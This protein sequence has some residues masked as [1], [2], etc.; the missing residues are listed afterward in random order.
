MSWNVGSVPDI[1]REPAPVVN[2]STIEI[3]LGWSTCRVSKTER[4]TVE[5]LPSYSPD[6]NPIEHLWR[7]IKRHNTHNRSFPA[8]SDLMTAV[9]TAL[10]H[11]QQHASE[12]KQLMGTYLDE[13]I[14]LAAA[15]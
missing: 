7:T 1:T 10:T 11:F 15:A 14:A 5:Q 6:Y 2:F 13:V 3:S 4:L 8:F 12:V 9:E